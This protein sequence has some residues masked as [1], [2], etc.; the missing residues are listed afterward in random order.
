MTYTALTH[1]RGHGTS[2]CKQTPIPCSSNLGY[3]IIMNEFCKNNNKTCLK[4][5]ILSSAY[6]CAWFHIAAAFY[7]ICE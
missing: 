7:A 4:I 1:T 2:D 6:C 5:I 3:K